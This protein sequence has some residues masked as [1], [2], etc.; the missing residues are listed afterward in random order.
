MK[1]N[2][3]SVQ[4]DCD[5]RDERKGWMGDAALTAEGIVLSYGMGAFY[6]HWLTQMMDS[7]NIDNGSMPDIVPPMGRI[8]GSPN[9]ETAYPMILWVMLTYY[10]DY[11]IV[12][13]HHDTLV[14]YFDYLESNY[15][16]TG[17]KTFRTG[18][19]DWVPPTPHPKSDPHLMGAFAF[20]GDLKLGMKIFRHS[21]HPEAGAQHDR[22]EKILSKVSDEYHDAFYNTTSGMYMSGLQTE[23]ALSL[24]LG[25]VP[26]D[27]KDSVLSSLISD[28]EVTNNVHTTSGIIGIK[29]C[30]E[31]LSM[32][33]RGDV[34]LDLALQT[35]Y[36][37]WG[38]MIN[39]PYEPATTV[40][41]LW[42]SDTAG[43]GMNSRNHHMFGSITSWFYK[44][45]AGI[46]P[47]DPGFSSIE[48]RPNLLR[49][50]N[51]SA[52][53]ASPRGDIS[54]NY[55]KEY[56]NNKKES[57]SMTFFYK[58]ILPPGTI[59]KLHIPIAIDDKEAALSIENNVDI[60]VEES[61]VPVWLG[62]KFVPGVNGIFTA[63]KLQ[64]NRVMFDISNGKYI[65]KV[66]ASKR[67]T[68]AINRR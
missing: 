47:L 67:A 13:R 55:W 60:F 58:V 48:I 68:S 9:W 8:N 33:D 57:N 17:I 44:H 51:F 27:L 64:N 46:R 56:N 16:E 28:I 26:T 21:Y 43:P 25:V 66:T 45:V 24:Y 36:P 19:G 15:N 54:L 41:E 31:V 29:Y 40:W 6:T 34:A 5:Q 20:L 63:T 37:S 14:R 23:Q 50:D 38:Y 32:L 10:G 61:G 65:F 7:Q 53:I 12:S 4:T 59:G 30:M 35:T 2:L 11:D 42:E 52:T 22:L 1:T 18:F 49:H 62:E 3:M 39:S